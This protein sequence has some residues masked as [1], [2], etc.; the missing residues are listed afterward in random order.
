MAVKI[1]YINKLALLSKQRCGARILSRGQL[2]M[3]LVADVAKQSHVVDARHVVGVLVITKGPWKHYSFNTQIC[4]LS[5]S[6]DSLLTF[7]RY[8]NGRNSTCYF[9][10]SV[11]SLCH[12]I[13]FKFEFFKSS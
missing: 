7:G 11:I 13:L 5:H 4:I 1:I 12:Y 9:N 3:P 6:N 8:L 2:W 10:Q